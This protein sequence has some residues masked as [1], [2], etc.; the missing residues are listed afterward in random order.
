MK[1]LKKLSIV[2]ILA[3]LTSC[4]SERALVNAQ[5]NVQISFQ[6]FYNELSPYGDWVE[7]YDYGYLWVPHVH[8]NFHP[9]ATDGYWTMT[10]YGNT[11][12]SNYSWGWAPFHYGRWLYDD[13]LG[14]AWVPGYEWA[15]A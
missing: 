14:W 11:W 15:P 13:Y 5:N 3:A 1:T 7:D 2:L 8:R 9:Y 12:V 4:Y 6:T 10:N